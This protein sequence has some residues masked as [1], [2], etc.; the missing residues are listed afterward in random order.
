MAFKTNFIS[1]FVVVCVLSISIQAQVI[2]GGCVTNDKCSCKYSDGA[3]IQLKYLGE[4]M[5]GYMTVSDSSG[6]SNDKYDFNPCVPF[7]VTGESG[8]TG[9]NNVVICQHH[10]ELY[11]I[12]SLSPY[13]PSFSTTQTG[14][15]Q[16]DYNDATG[17]LRS[18]K[19]KCICDK[20]YTSMPGLSSQ[21]EQY[22]KYGFEM[23]HTC[24]CKDGCKDGMPP[25]GIGSLSGG[26]ILLIICFV[27][28]AVY[29]IAGALFMKYR[30][31]AI[32][33]EIIPNKSFWSEI[34]SLVK[35]GVMFVLSPCTK[36]SSYNQV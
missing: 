19:V 18:S 12:G 6:K 1:C 8:G 14:D 22:N 35:D 32:G 16:I 5:N 17:Y 2:P 10:N 4:Y 25:G 20:S 24:C 34:P 11:D 15:V 3:V 33:S 26:S 31:G 30:K 29:L 23:R 13:P 36:R 27:F 28:L 21:G 9:C 7:T